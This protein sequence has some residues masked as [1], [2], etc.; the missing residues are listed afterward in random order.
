MQ[1]VFPLLRVA[2][3][4]SAVYSFVRSM[5]T[6]SAVIFLIAP[7]LELP[8]TAVLTLTTD[9]KLSGAAALSTLLV[10]VIA[11]AVAAARLVLRVPV[12]LR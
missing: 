8:A 12:V 9:G 6:L 4:S 7:G 5:V 3:F 10:A 11:L 1:V 2:F